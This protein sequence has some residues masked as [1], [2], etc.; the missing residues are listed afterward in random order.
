MGRGCRRVVVEDGIAATGSHGHQRWSHPATLCPFLPAPSR[1]N[2]DPMLIR[3]GRAEDSEDLRAIE[4]SAGARFEE[5]GMDWV[6]S[7]EPM[8]ADELEGYAR[9][10]RSWVAVGEDGRPVGY[11]VV[12]VMDGC[13]HIEQVSVDFEHQGNGVGRAL[14][15]EVEA[16]AAS[17]N[18]G[19]L[20]LTTFSDVAWN[21]PLYEHLGFSV[22][23]EEDL[24]PGLVAVREEESR[25][26]LDRVARVCMRKAVVPTA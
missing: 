19:A 25:R 7:H 24:S 17:R 26:G 5:V 14:I 12:E 18:L 10:G 16:W 3:P 15:R 22:V 6:A 13:A 23:S 11:V 8:S 1:S 2:F 4:R 20:T 9:A 21:R